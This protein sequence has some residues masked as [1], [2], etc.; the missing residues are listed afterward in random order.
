MTGR[1]LPIVQGVVFAAA[2]GIVG[3]A[4]VSLLGGDTEVVEVEVDEKGLPLSAEELAERDHDMLVAAARNET[5][6]YGVMIKAFSAAGPGFYGDGELEIDDT[7]KVFDAV[8]D[9]IERMAEQPRRLRQREWHEVYRAANDAFTAL[10]MHLD[11]KDR[12]QAKE[13]EEAHQRL[14]QG[15]ASVRV[16]G[17]KFRIEL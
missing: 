5:P 15:L 9:E 1:K 4:L 13:L 16:R 14:R 6:G 17:K 12:D 11:A 7:R 3:V 2:L 8:M 10:S